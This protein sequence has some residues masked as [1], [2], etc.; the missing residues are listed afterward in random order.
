MCINDRPLVM[1]GCVSGRRGFDLT[2]ANKMLSKT[3]MIVFPSGDIT[4]NVVVSDVCFS[5]I[6][7]IAM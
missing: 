6:L 3:K 7:K 1:T 2:D 5:M 4:L